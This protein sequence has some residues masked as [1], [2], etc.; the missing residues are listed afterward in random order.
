[1]TLGKET[2]PTGNTA[3]A[4]ISVRLRAG[5]GFMTL[6]C[7]QARIA[8]GT[9]AVKHLIKML[10]M[11]MGVMVVVRSKNGTTA[12]ATKAGRIEIGMIEI[13]MMRDKPL[14][15]I[16]MFPT[17]SRRMSI[18]GIGRKE[19]GMARTKIGVALTS[20]EIDKDIRVACCHE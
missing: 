12:T 5:T 18:V 14:A 7:P 11:L 2:S 8:T 4:A 20:I 19:T 3:R 15:N 13:G 17:M 9:S 16:S 1:M 10:C 6:K